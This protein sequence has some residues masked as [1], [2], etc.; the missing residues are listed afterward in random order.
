MSQETRH[1]HPSI[2]SASKIINNHLKLRYTPLILLSALTAFSLSLLLLFLGGAQRWAQQALLPENGQIIVSP[3]KLQLAGLQLGSTLEKDQLLKQLQ[4]DV[5]I[6]LAQWSELTVPSQLRVQYGQFRLKTDLVVLAVEPEVLEPQ[7]AKQ[8]HLKN[9]DG[10]QTVV[11]IVIPQYLVELANLSLKSNTSLPYLSHD[12]LIGR[13]LNL[14]L[15]L[16]SF[17]QSPPIYHLTCEIVGISDRIGYT[18]PAIPL[19]LA[20]QLYPEVKPSHLAVIPED[21]QNFGL[22]Y[23]KAKELG[24]QIQG[25]HLLDPLFT[26]Q[27]TGQI[28]TL[29]IVTIIG[30]FLYFSWGLMLELS[31]YQNQKLFLLA[32]IQG[33]SQSQLSTITLKQMGFHYLIG[34][35]MGSIIALLTLGGILFCVPVPSSLISAITQALPMSY[36]AS[37]IFILS[38]GLILSTLSFFSFKQLGSGSLNKVLK[39][40]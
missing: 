3:R 9:Y 5:P 23:Q 20:Q 13:R 26:A 22:L 36:G 37:I 8:F 16:S 25:E 33:V 32:Q 14:D 40:G 24:L 11:P 1:N 10:P 7:I 17:A 15:G 4:L 38:L 12:F 19:S 34:S 18:G 27:G 2:P 39:Q 29:I 6:H 21:P 35:L 30:L 28:L 31:Y